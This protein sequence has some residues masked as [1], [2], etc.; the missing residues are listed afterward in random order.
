MASL[1]RLP[2][3][4]DAARIHPRVAYV[5]MPAFAG[6]RTT[7]HPGPTLFPCRS[8]VKYL[9]TAAGCSIIRGFAAVPVMPVP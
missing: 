6:M 1:P 8:R 4:G 7:N 9:D 3:K 2:P 5:R